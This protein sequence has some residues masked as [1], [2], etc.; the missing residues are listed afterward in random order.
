[1][2][3]A[4]KKLVLSKETLRELTD[5][6]SRGVL[7]GYTNAQS[8]DSTWTDTCTASRWYTCSN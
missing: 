3:K 7:G 4:S 2:K 1:M 8:G 6:E 5:I